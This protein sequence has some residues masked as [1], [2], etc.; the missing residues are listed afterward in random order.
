MDLNKCFP[1]FNGMCSRFMNLY[2]DAQ[3]DV[4]Y[5]IT[6]GHPKCN[7]DDGDGRTL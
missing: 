1:Q 5:F 6:S 3:K 2:E 7:D 4:K